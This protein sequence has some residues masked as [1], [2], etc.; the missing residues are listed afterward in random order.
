MITAEVSIYPLKTNDSTDVINS[1]IGVL[2]NKNVNYSVN[3]MS[4]IL[5]GEKDEV[6]ASLSNMFDEAQK[7][8]GEIS[9]VVTVSNAA[10]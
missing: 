8:G 5:K 6:F 2:N 10:D 1:S 4:T 7:K 9:M 3:S